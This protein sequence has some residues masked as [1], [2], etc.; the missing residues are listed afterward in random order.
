M[1]SK[2]VKKKKGEKDT[3]EEAAQEETE[4]MTEEELQEE[5]AAMLEEAMAPRQSPASELRVA[6]MYGEIDDKM[7]QERQSHCKR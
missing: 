4:E 2:I 5:L 3:E 7:A 1:S 6:Q